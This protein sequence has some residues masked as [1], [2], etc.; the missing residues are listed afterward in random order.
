MT[1]AQQ[2][3]I[4]HATVEAANNGF[5]FELKEPRDD[6]EGAALT[7]KAKTGSAYET[8]GISPDGWV[9]T[10][11]SS[12][13]Y[14]KDLSKFTKKLVTAGKKMRPKPEKTPKPPKAPARRCSS[15]NFKDHSIIRQ[16]VDRVHVGA[17]E[18][19]VL[20]YAKSRLAPKAWDKMPEADRKA[21][22][23]EV[24]KAHDRNRATYRRVMR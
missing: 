23:C 4:E 7:I 24:L 2:R 6:R 14:D 19:E 5:L 9:G 8:L 17:S 12:Q 18:A 1:P 3:F 20:E 22:E 16:I 15:G 11:S 10:V 21:F 13:S